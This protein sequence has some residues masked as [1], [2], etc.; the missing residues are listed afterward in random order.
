MESHWIYYWRVTEATGKR[1]TTRH[2]ATEEDIRAQQP[3]ARALERIDAGKLWINGVPTRAHNTS[4]FSP[5]QIMRKQTTPP[6]FDS[7][8]GWYRNGTTP[9]GTPAAL[10]AMRDAALQCVV[11]PMRLRGVKRPV[12]ELLELNPYAGALIL[13]DDFTKPNWTAMLY[14]VPAMSIVIMSMHEVDVTRAR[15]GFRQISGIEWGE[16]AMARWP[17]TWFCAPNVEAAQAVL[18]KMGAS[19]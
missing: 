3:T 7:G 11:Y 5:P 6:T 15:G 4:F 9:P 17:Q 16:K 10:Q 2:R 14:E 13:N 19:T 1:Y 12:A 8:S 18:A